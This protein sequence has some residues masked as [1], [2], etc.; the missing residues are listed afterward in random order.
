MHTE[1]FADTVVVPGPNLRSRFVETEEVD[2]A[3]VEQ[4]DGAEDDQLADDAGFCPACHRVVASTER[5]CPDDDTTLVT[6]PPPPSA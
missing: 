5:V 1:E 3:E 4:V 6:L 2:D